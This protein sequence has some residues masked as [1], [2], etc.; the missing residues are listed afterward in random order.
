MKNDHKFKKILA[1]WPTLKRLLKMTFKNHEWM[2][3]VSFLAIIIST[4]ASVIGTLFLQ[5]LF[6][7]YI[8]PLVKSANPN[9]FPL[10][11]AVLYMGLI[12]LLGILAVTLYTQLMAILGQKVQLKLRKQMF[13]KMQT[14]PI[15]YFDNHNY[16]DIMSRYTNDIDT[17]LQMITQSLPQLVNVIFNLTFVIVGMLYLSWQLTIIS[18][19]IFAISIIFIRFLTIKSSFYFNK[20]Q[21]QLGRT[22]AYIEETLTGQKV[23]QLFSH[24]EETK[25]SFFKLNDKLRI[26]FGKANGYAMMLF[27][28]MGNLG[29]ALYVLVALIGGYLSIKHYVPLTLGTIAA[30]LQL[31][32]SF[33]QPIS[34]FSQQLNSV[35]MAL[36]GGKRIFNLLDQKSEVDEG[37]ITLTDQNGNYSWQKDS[38][39]TPLLGKVEFD[40]VNFGYENDKEILHD[41]NFKVNPGDKVALVGETGAGKSTIINLLTRFYEINDGQIKIDGINT[42]NISKESLRKLFGMVL[43]QTNLFTG[44]ILD[45]IKYGDLSVSDQQLNNAI[46]LANLDSFVNQLKDGYNTIIK[47]EGNGL[48]QGQRQLI[49]IARVAVVN[50]PI[51]ILDEATSNIDTRTERQVQQAMDNL[52]QNRTSFVIAHRLSTIFNADLILVVY[53]GRIIEQGNHQQLIDK[54]GKYFNLYNNSLVLD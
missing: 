46:K 26:Y 37:K 39:S 8:T 38:N 34:Q 17:L 29:N 49:S 31:S 45:N 6:D 27:P 32:K 28:F 14:L 2:I 21:Q 5:K 25:Q 3:F 15:S 30:F 16:G 41:I 36:A 4:L 44:S 42:K 9:F 35:V 7:N 52:M 47:G 40:H 1:E 43:Q 22:N 10:F 12:Y 24:E 51:V 33:S 23:V 11:K 13:S 48:S 54:H 53:N 20:R 50:P 19:V 18:L